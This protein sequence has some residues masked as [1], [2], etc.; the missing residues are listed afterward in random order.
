LFET[1]LVCVD[2]SE[3]SLKAA[4]LALN[5]AAKYEAGVVALNVNQASI[6]LLDA[7][8]YAGSLK[9]EA[10]REELQ[11]AQERVRAA[12]F[13][14]YKDSGIHLRFR[15]EVGQPVSVI[16][17]VAEQERANLIVLGSR[18]VGVFKASL[19][20]SVSLGVLDH[21]PCPVLVVR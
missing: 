3:H 21:S 5:L 13:D 19:T 20:G 12:I 10:Y 16:V 18:G 7:S 9:S 8:A 11:L 1:I 15:G 17:S 4:R 2:E 6:P 14:V